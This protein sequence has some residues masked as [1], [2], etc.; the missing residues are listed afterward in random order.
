MFARANFLIE[1][2]ERFVGSFKAHFGGGG[3]QDRKRKTTTFGKLG[4]VAKTHLFLFTILMKK[5]DKIS[6]AF[7]SL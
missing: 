6:N 3:G 2:E 7:S 5:W 4:S 1:G